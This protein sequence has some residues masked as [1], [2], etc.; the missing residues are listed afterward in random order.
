VAVKI[1]SVERKSPCD[2]KGIKAGD[3]LV[4]INGNEIFDQLDY[5]FY[6]ADSRLELVW[7]NAGGKL[8]NCKLKHCE[9]IDS[10]GL[11]FE[12]FLM[13]KQHSCLNKC[14]FCFI[15]QMPPGMRE[16][17]YFKDDD[18]RLS[19]LFGNYI[20]LTNLSAHDADR[21][22]KMHISP[23]NVSVHTMNPELRVKMMANRHAGEV[24]SYLDD[25]SAA[26]ISI[27][28]Q[29]VLCPGINDG[30][31]LE[32]SLRRLSELENVVSIA[33]V[34]VGLTKYRDGLYPLESYTPVT[35]GAV[36][37][38]IEKFN[39]SLKQ[40]GRENLAF[41]SDEFYLTAGRE[42]PPYEYY[43]D[44]PQLDN[45]VGMWV[46]SQVEFADELSRSEADAK[47]REFGV[48]T[49]MLAA[50]LMEGFVADFCDK[51][52][53]TRA[54]VF[55]VKNKFF[56]ESVTVAGLVTGQDLIESLRQAGFNYPALLV[57]S[58]MIKSETE[59]IFLDD[60]TVEEVEKA[61]ST[62]V[63]INRCAGADL[64]TAMKEV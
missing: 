56:G 24:L 54:E 23:V 40:S 53:N 15:D 41:A 28:A 12:T 37:D 14:I 59:R 30:P 8:K 55:A 9:G 57:P 52:T 4:S 29:L 10:C 17:L 32:Y 7:K 5:S 20:T 36:I 58:V 48:A 27:N 13:D 34:P 6:G 18:S 63:I 33:A 61:L 25:F 47:R 46:S 11:N 3:E 45:G 2:K 50:P 43:G 51:F 31:E 35:A 26:G 39:E 22:K 49:G 62:R 19:F 16:S 42:F 44:F 1:A 64:V 60:V 21:I 38:I